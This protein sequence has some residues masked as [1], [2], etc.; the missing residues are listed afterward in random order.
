MNTIEFFSYIFVNNEARSL[1]IY[2]RSPKS[3]FNLI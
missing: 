3:D 2:I 1:Y